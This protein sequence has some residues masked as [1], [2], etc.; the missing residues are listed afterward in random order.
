MVT[1][2]PAEACAG[3]LDRLR[4]DSAEDTGDVN[5][6]W[7]QPRDEW[8]AELANRTVHTV[9]HIGCVL[10]PAGGYRG[11]TAVLVKSNGRFGVPYLAAIKPF[12]YLGVYPALLRMIG[13]DWQAGPG[14][15]PG[16]AV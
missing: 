14:A 16:P 12:R 6:S 3:A 8:A 7:D 15:A 4:A 1:G 5:G 10:D 2:R 11:Q 9:I 13:R